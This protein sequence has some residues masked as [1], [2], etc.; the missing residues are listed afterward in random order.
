MFNDVLVLKGISIAQTGSEQI[1]AY[2]LCPLVTSITQIVI[3]LASCSVLSTVRHGR[4]HWDQFISIPQKQLAFM[5]YGE[6]ISSPYGI[7]YV[8]ICIC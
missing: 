8:S 4:R 3:K 1:W 7:V 2:R 6:F 5:D